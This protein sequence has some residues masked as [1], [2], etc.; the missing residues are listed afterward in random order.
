MIIAHTPV[1]VNQLRREIKTSW[2]IDETESEN[3]YLKMM[4]EKRRTWNGCKISFDW[5]C[6]SFKPILLSG[7]LAAGL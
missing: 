7:H 1:V 3:M 4:T 6:S 5:C 2:K